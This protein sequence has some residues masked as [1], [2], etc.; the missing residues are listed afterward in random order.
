MGALVAFLSYLTKSEVS[1]SFFLIAL[2]GGFL[3][4]VHVRLAAQALLYRARRRGRYL[5]RLLAVGT[6]PDIQN[7]LAQVS[8]PKEHGL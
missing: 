2:P 5:H 7:L 8:Q 6:S 4:L 1:R 3:A